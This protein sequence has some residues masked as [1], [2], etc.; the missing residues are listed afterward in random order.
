MSLGRGSNTA[1]LMAPLSVK[2]CCAQRASRRRRQR[3][4]PGLELHRQAKRLE[5]RGLREPSN[6]GYATGVKGEHHDPVRAMDPLLGSEHVSGDSGLVVRARRRKTDLMERPA[7]RD[8]LEELAYPLRSDESHWERR[9]RQHRIVSQ[10]SDEP[11]DIDRI[12]RA[13]EVLKNPPRDRVRR[14]GPIDRKPPFAA[15]AL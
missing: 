9:H 7:R 14:N 8:P 6:L 2:T 15:L 11:L 1:Q 3:S 5:E 13:N 12:P 10:Q 4:V